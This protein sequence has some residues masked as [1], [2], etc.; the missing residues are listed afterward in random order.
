MSE[1]R[2]ES[3]IKKGA[4]EDLAEAHEILRAAEMGKG[5]S[6]EVAD[7]PGLNVNMDYKFLE[8]IARMRSPIGWMEDKIKI[9]PH[10]LS[11]A[12]LVLFSLTWFLLGLTWAS[13][14]FIGADLAQKLTIIVVVI[15]PLVLLI[16]SAMLF[17]QWVVSVLQRSKHK[18][19]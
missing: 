14:A 15:V 6:P 5:E 18:N 4:K 10:S 13:R 9:V 11:I 3:L 16:M 8:R 19:K 1:G 7:V 17:K 2:F 12:L